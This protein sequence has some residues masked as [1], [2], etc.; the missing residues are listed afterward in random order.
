M[1]KLRI[2]GAAL[3]QT[4]LDW[5][6]NFENI[7][8]AINEAKKQNIDVLCLPELCIPGYGC[9]DLFN[10]Q[11]LIERSVIQLQKIIPYCIN[12][13]VAMGLPIVFENKTYNC[14][15]MIKDGRILGISAKQHLANGGVYYEPRWFTP[16]P[17][18][19]VAQIEIDNN[20]YDIGDIIY[21]IDGIKVG[22][23]ICEDAWIKDRP[24]CRLVEK[25]IDLILNPS[26]SHFAFEKSIERQ[27]LVIDSSKKFNC[28]YLYV[29]LLGN[30]AGEI[31]YDGEILLAR[32]G[33]YLSKNRTF[34]FVNYSIISNDI[35]FKKSVAEN[36][37]ET[38]Y[39][40]RNEQ[41][42][43]AVSL[44]LFDYL[45]KS[46]SQGFVISLSGG[47]DSSC[48]A[49]LVA[50][51]IK[52]GVDELGIKEFVS[53]AGLSIDEDHL[54][55]LTIKQLTS[56]ILTCAY[57][58][59]EN[60]SAK[61]LESAGNLAKEVGAQFFHWDINN[62]VNVFNTIIEKALNQKLTWEKDDIT[63]QNIQARTRSPL[64]WMLAN[65]KNSLLL[66][67]SN[68]SEADVGYATMDGDTSGSLAPIA[69]ISKTFL[70]N[71][72][73]WAQNELGYHC[74]E[75]V[76]KLTPTA[77]LRPGERHQTDETDL[78]PYPILEKI[79]RLAI[80]ERKSPAQIYVTLNNRQI[81]APELLAK[82]ID[83]FFTLLARNQWKRE[84]MAPSFQLDDFNINPRSWFRFPIL[85]AGFLE[86]LE[87][88]RKNVKEQL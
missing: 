7:V 15:C 65:I 40:P 88:L 51:M 82:H 34:Q 42:A 29:N 70:K 71:W 73:E 52:R 14:A 58:A 72:L 77:E 35:D 4:P 84:R 66:T 25:N 9:E 5:K 36:T 79:E 24:A 57:Q 19:K 75:D 68:R 49:V 18:E 22:F 61:T 80:W 60:S 59:T 6:G 23:E 33:Q 50:E 30:E 27:K 47:A 56:K 53:K 78:M 31:I 62:A 2:G 3:N 76:N 17:K 64:I 69:G 39:L 63:L 85:S 45:R 38:E 1:P 13:T 48:C 12:I 32:N 86:E 26:G 10:H 81:E 83:K 28:A 67:T 20:Y 21:E 43:R 74:L 54:A 37:I 8:N 46:H 87:E 16:W 44:G 11:W 41:F 55:D